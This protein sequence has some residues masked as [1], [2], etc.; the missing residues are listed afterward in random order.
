ML[1]RAAVSG[2]DP[3]LTADARADSSGG[4]RCVFSGARRVEV[5]GVLLGKYCDSQ[6]KV[7]DLEPVECEHAFGPLI[8]SLLATRSA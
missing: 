3:L 2:P 6:V 7:T 4:G 1:A 5:G 8:F